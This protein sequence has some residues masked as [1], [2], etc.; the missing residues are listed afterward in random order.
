MKFNTYNCNITNNILIFSNIKN[1]YLYGSKRKTRISKKTS[2][3]ISTIEVVKSLVD[4][5]VD[6]YAGKNILALGCGDLF[7]LERF[8]EDNQVTTF[9]GVDTLLLF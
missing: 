2:L 6:N 1:N 5:H 8:S 4:H 3:G 9:I 7:F